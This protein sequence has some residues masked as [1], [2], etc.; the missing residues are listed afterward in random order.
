MKKIVIF[1]LLS[2]PTILS[3]QHSL[4]SGLN[5]FRADDVIIKQQVEY[6][7]PGRTGANVLW[8]FSQLNVVNDEYELAYSS[9][10][11]TLITGT[12]HLTQYHYVLQNDSLLLWGF[13]NQTTQLHNIQPELLLK[14]PVNYRDTVQSY[15][16]AHGKYG[17]RLELDAMGTIETGADAYGMMILPNKDTLKPVL[18]THTIKYIV[19]DIRP[20]NDSYYEKLESPL[21]ISPD[22]IDQRLAS[23]SVIFVVETFRWYEKGYR[24]PI[25]ET[26]RSW[27]QYRTNDDYEFLNTAFFYPPQE[28]YYLDNDEENLAI[29]EN[30]ANEN[31]NN[32]IVDPWEGLTYNIYPNPVKTSPLEVEL[33]LPKPATIQAQLRSTMGTVAVDVNKGYHPAGIYHFQLDAF[34]LPVGNYILNIWLDEKLISEIIM[35]R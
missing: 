32:E 34:N 6:K 29:L 24:Y 14:F 33:Y 2:I 5:M 9:Y 22:S 17:N 20:I 26:V 27:E 23:D 13:D 21:V 3:A 15:Y 11:D 10:N 8:D 25:F 31:E 16:Y 19:E 4:Q 30:E 1:L 7:D 28:H 18:R 12:E 35:K